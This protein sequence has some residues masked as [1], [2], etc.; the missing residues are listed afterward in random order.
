MG[1]QSTIEA[2][3][4]WTEHMCIQLAILQGQLSLGKEVTELANADWRTKFK[5]ALNLSDIETKEHYDVLLAPYGRRSE[6]S[7]RMT[8][9]VSA[10][11]HFTSTRAKARPL[12]C[13]RVEG[14]M[15]T[16]SLVTLVSMKSAP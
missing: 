5:A 6:I 10:V 13:C 8:R 2:F 15:D 16:H 12:C 3:F 4:S 14:N 1:A 11:R 7:W 9:L